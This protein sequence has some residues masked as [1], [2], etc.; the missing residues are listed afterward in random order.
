M[1]F[2]LFTCIDWIEFYTSSST[3]ASNRY[4]HT[5]QKAA[6]PSPSPPPLS[7]TVVPQYFRD[8]EA[9][10]QRL[11]D[12]K[13]KTENSYSCEFL[14]LLCAVI[15]ATLLTHPVHNFS[16]LSNINRI[17]PYDM[18]RGKCVYY[19]VGCDF[20][21]ATCFGWPELHHNHVSIFN[22]CVSDLLFSGWTL[23]FSHEH[24]FAPFTLHRPK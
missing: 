20:F 5:S 7:P 12:R 1:P 4:F 14:P 15:N 13:I 11:N 21:L 9:E 8:C 23:I 18:V 16:L 3:H 17:I 22:K 2:R 19:T 24:V 6:T 10:T